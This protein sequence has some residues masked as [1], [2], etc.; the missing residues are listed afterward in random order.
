[1]PMHSRALSLAVVLALS[2]GCGDDAP[3]KPGHEPGLSATL[4]MQMWNAT[5]GTRACMY[6]Y[7]YSTTE[8]GPVTG[9]VVAAELMAAGERRTASITIPKGTVV[10]TSS[11]CWHPDSGDVERA[12]YSTDRTVDATQTCL[13][14]YNFVSTGAVVD[15]SCWYGTP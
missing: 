2:L 13:S 1:M 4:Y 11:G 3:P 7:A 15:Y 5:D 6:T 10:S 9:A 8:S 14:A 12:I